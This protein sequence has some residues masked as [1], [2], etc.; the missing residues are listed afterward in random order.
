MGCCPD[1]QFVSVST[2]DNFVTTGGDVV[3]GATV[4]NNTGGSILSG[5]VTLTNSP[6]SGTVTA[7]LANNGTNIIGPITSGNSQTVYVSNIGTL[8]AFSGTAGQPVSGRV[9]V[10]AA[11]QVA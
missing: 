5:Y 9:C 7:F 2:C 4:F 11:R 10:D 8:V 6:T 1:P 3:G